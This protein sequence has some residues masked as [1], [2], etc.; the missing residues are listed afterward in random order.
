[1]EVPLYEFVSKIVYHA[2]VAA[3]F[4]EDLAADKSLFKAFRD[5]D[6]NLPLAAAGVH[7]NNFTTSK[8]GKDQLAEVFMKCRNGLCDFMNARW[9]TFT[10]GP[11]KLPSD[12]VIGNFQLAI[13]WASVGNSMPACFWLI[14]NLI[15]NP[16]LLQRVL[17]EIHSCCKKGGEKDNNNHNDEVDLESFGQEE[18]NQMLFL[19]AC[20]TETLRLA[21]GS[22]IMRVAKAPCKISLASG[23]TYN[24]RKGDRIGLC[25]PLFHLDDELFPNPMSFNPDRWMQGETFEERSAA[26]LGKISLKKDG[27]EIMG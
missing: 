3:L 11:Y 22:L 24:I 13:H 5:H 9:K 2:S 10:E 25:P 7:I 23:K 16:H 17:D 1:M 4:N 14:F 12:Q 26:V 6:H 21:S 19:D 15:R 18:L 20:L 27:K 8:K